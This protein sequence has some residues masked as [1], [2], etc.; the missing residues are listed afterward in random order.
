MSHFDI[1]ERGEGNAPQIYEISTA[2]LTLLT[3]SL[4]VQ[5][6]YQMC[7]CVCIAGCLRNS[8]CSAVLHFLWNMWGF[9][10]LFHF[11]LRHVTTNSSRS[12]TRVTRPSLQW[13]RR[14]HQV[15]LV[16]VYLIF[17][18]E[19]N[20]NKCVTQG[21]LVVMIIINL[22]KWLGVESMYIYKKEKNNCFHFIQWSKNKKRRRKKS[23]SILLIWSSL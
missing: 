19:N 15:G 8:R 1:N 6:L 4:H 12:K 21:T 11:I 3:F 16:S 2:L 13:P 9:R 20:W 7:V 18:F 17:F 14:S 5:F 22:V 10:H 23:H